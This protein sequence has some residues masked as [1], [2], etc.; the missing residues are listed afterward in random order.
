M[1]LGAYD[2]TALPA[3]QALYRRIRAGRSLPATD[4][5]DEARAQGRQVVIAWRGGEPVGCAGW[6][7]VG[8]ADDGRLYGSPVI[9]AETPVAVRLIDRLVTEGRALCAT[10]LRIS[11]WD[12]EGAKAVALA[13]AGFVR[14]F[15]WVTFAREIKMQAVPPFATDGLISISQ[16]ELD[17]PRLAELYATTFRGV[18]NAPP[19]DAATLAA[20]WIE[21]DWDASCVLADAAGRYFAFVVAHGDGSIDVIGVDASLRG[22]GLAERLYCHAGNRLAAN[23][24]RQLTALVSSANVASL[25]FHQKLG[26]AESEPRGTVWELEL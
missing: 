9:A 17:W 16:A 4:L 10:H 15:D 20:E 22:T 13:A 21:A 11:A 14:L 3:L 24:V 26:F 6:V 5:T 19:I 8:I 2:P 23:G 25:R 1:Q 18:P 12:G 7:V